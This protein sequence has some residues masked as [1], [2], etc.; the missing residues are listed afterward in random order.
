MNLVSSWAMSRVTTFMP[1]YNHAS[2]IEQAIQ[3]VLS[4]D[5]FEI[6]LIVIDDCSTNGS[7][8]TIPALQRELN[9][10]YVQYQQN[11]NL[12]PTSVEGYRT[13]TSKCT[14][15]LASDDA[16]LPGKLRKQVAYLGNTGK[17]DVFADG[18]KL[19]DK[20]RTETIDLKPVARRFRNGTMCNYTYVND[21][22]V[23]LFQSGPPLKTAILNL[24]SCCTR[25]KSDDRISLIRLLE[26]YDVTFLNEPFFLYRQ[27]SINPVH[28]Y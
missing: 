11:R 20:G 16:L 4:Q 5:Y 25:H 21:V 3:S 10:R 2:C 13:G 22:Q 8:E 9:F 27:H 19:W 24:S 7:P 28:C 26:K 12:N 15:M 14:T 18:L 6:K 1:S 23:P 17:D